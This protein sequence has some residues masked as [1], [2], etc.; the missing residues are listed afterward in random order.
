MPRNI[1]IKVGIFIIISVLLIGASVGY[2]AYKKD[3]FSK[4]YTFT[5]M[6]KSGDGFSEG[7]PLVFAGFK[8]GTV[9]TMALSDKGT[10]LIKINIPE[11]HIKW[12]RKSSIFILERPLIG[13]PR[14]VVYTDEMDSPVLSTDM[15]PEIFHVDSIDEAIHKVQPLL[16]KIDRILDNVVTISSK[17]SQKETLMEM[18]V[19]DKESVSSVNEF[20]QSI[21]TMGRRLD[22]ILSKVDTVIARTDQGL[23]GSDGLVVLLRT[24]LTDIIGKLDRLNSVIDDIPTVTGQ[25]V[26]S[27]GDLDNLRKDID[28]TI[29]AVQEL[30]KDIDK[31]IPMKKEREI[32]V[33]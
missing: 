15:A 21:D 7:M 2:V 32:N 31:M 30:L 10:V 3:A 14:I 19:G 26:R 23:Y 22:T 1:E 18:A 17:L 20:L 5:F 16:T 28:D 12:T 29:H 4:V 11:R 24:V 6:S 13:Q 25:V 8:I 9:D 33:P 27:T